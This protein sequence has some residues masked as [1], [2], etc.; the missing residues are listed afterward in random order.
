M[1]LENEQRLV[2]MSM[3]LKSVA[4]QL[5]ALTLRNRDLSFVARMLEYLP[6]LPLGV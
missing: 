6:R 3:Q 4:A 2:D 5:G 1:R